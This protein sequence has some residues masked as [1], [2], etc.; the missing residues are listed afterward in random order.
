VTLD[1]IHDAREAV[2]AVEV[3]RPLLESVAK[4]RRRLGGEGLSLSDR[5][6]KESLTVVRAKAW[7]Q[8][9]TYAV[10]DDLGVLS[11][12]LWD[13]PASEPIVRGFVLDIANPQEKRAREI[14]DAL[15]VAWKNLQGLEE[16]RERTM[17]AVEFLSKLRT[18]RAEL[19]GFRDRVQ[20]RKAETAPIDFILA[21]TDRYE[22]Q[23]KRDYLE[24]G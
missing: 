6:Y 2:I 13:D 8:G 22:A 3:D 21:E 17:A 16:E 10:E 23:V 9:R 20:R 4:I 19:Q 7:L 15:Q 18:A 12:I 1:E 5:R 14:A 11:N 24:S